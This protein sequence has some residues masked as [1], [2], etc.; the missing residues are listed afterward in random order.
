MTAKT[1]TAQEAFKREKDSPVV[2]AI[3]KQLGKLSEQVIEWEVTTRE[4]YIYK[5]AFPDGS[6][7]RGEVMYVWQNR[8]WIAS[9]TKIPSHVAKEPK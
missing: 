8:E 1:N 2:Q 7:I 5:A 3:L 6:E 4:P 9:G